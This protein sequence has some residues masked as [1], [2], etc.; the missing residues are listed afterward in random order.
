VRWASAE[1]GAPAAVLA[2]DSSGGHLALLVALRGVPTA[3]DQWLPPDTPRDDPA[4]SPLLADLTGLPATLVVTASHDPLRDEGD[5]LARALATAGVPVIHRCEPGMVHGF[6]QNL[7]LVSPA[8]GRVGARWLDDARF[9]ERS[10]TT[11]L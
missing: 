3:V 9:P 11:C 6:I 7:D 8:A 5:E 2:G 10:M 1:L 4:V